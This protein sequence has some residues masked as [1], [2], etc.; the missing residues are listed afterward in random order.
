MAVYADHAALANDDRLYTCKTCGEQFP[1]ARMAKTRKVGRVYTYRTCLPCTN[2]YKRKLERKLA[3]A[4]R[5]EDGT[6]VEAPLESDPAPARLLVEL[7]RE[8]RQRW[9]FDFAAAWTEDVAFVLARIPNPHQRTSWRKALTSTRD[10]WAAAWANEPG[11]GERLS[12]ALVDES[13]AEPSGERTS[14]RL[15]VA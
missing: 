8:D 3:S 1:A 15:D 6:I 13:S 7:L 4:P 10:A 5:G 9:R 2:V 14:L 12:P 11:P